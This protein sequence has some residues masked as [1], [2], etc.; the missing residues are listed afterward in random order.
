MA[1]KRKRWRDSGRKMQ[2]RDWDRLRAAVSSDPLRVRLVGAF[3]GNGNQA[4]TIASL[5]PYSRGSFFD[6]DVLNNL[7][8]KRGVP[9]RLTV[10]L[11]DRGLRGVDRAKK[12]YHFTIREQ[13]PS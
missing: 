13:V 2:L 9:Y 7:L 11:G 5:A 3:R 10:L 6:R 4:L 8:R 1:T 12:R